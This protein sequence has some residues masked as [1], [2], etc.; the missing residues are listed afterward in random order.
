VGTQQDQPHQFSFDPWLNVDFRRR[1][2]ASEGGLR[3]SLARA[4]ALLSAT[5]LLFMARPRASPRPAPVAA[6]RTPGRGR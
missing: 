4:A 1:R 6:M 5:L 2:A 3:R